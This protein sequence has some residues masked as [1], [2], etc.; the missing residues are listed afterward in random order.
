MEPDLEDIVQNATKEE[1]GQFLTSLEKELG[2]V[3]EQ[4]R[5][6]KAALTKF[7]FTAKLPSGKILPLT[8]HDKTRAW[9]V[10]IQFPWTHICRS[11][12]KLPTR[13][14]L[15]PQLFPSFYWV[16]NWILISL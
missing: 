14:K 3:Q 1:L 15:L 12:S 5:K 11:S 8:G 13:R 16:L 4:N 2:Q 9:E 10:N 6:L 7:S